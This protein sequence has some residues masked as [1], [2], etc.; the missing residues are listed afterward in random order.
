MPV[1][2]QADELGEDDD[3]RAG[4]VDRLSQIIISGGA[5]AL[6]FPDAAK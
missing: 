5:L 4:E 1:P 6:P 2:S 3:T